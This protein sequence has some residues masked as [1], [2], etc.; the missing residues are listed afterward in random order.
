M[1]LQALGPVHG[2]QLDRVGLGGGG[3]VEPVALVVL[4]GE[5]GEQG[6]QGHLAVDGLELSDRLEEQVEVVAAGR[7]GGADCRGELDVDAR[8][9]DDA[10]DDVEDRLTAASLGGELRVAMSALSPDQACAVRLRVIEELDYSLEA[11]S[12]RAFAA[13]Y[14]RRLCGDPEYQFL[15]PLLEALGT[16]C[17]GSSSSTDSMNARIPPLRPTL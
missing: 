2:Q 12:Q 10:P 3:H 14:V 11:D 8:D 7:G 9:V 5:V 16:M 13:A 1:P 17:R 15:P 4:R 6:R